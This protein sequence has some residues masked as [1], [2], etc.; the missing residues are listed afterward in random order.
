MNFYV[1]SIASAIGT[2]R[3]R[4]A[5]ADDDDFIKYKHDFKIRKK[6]CTKEQKVEQL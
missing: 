3:C 2:A 1:M 6:P 4:F 5:A